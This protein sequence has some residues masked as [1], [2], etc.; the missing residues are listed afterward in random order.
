VKAATSDV[1]N[2]AMIQ[3]GARVNLGF[4]DNVDE[5]YVAAED[6]YLQRDIIDKDGDG[7]EDNTYYTSHQ[8]DKFR[9][10]WVYGDVE[11]M[12]NTRNGEL[13]GHHLKNDH[14]EPTGHH[15]SHI[16]DLRDHATTSAAVVAAAKAAAPAEPAAAAAPAAEG[17]AAAAPAEDKPAEDK[18]VQMSDAVQDIDERADNDN[19]REYSAPA[20]DQQIDVHPASKEPMPIGKRMAKIDPVVAAQIQEAQ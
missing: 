18:K 10:P 2:Q 4:V 5:I 6:V 13:P 17:E 11:E 14:P 20:M 16:P 9:I 15:A 12:H 8:L 1:A 19:D 3:T 7:V